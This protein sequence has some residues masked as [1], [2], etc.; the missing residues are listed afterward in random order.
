MELG[1]NII[2]QFN[3]YLS[4]KYENSQTDADGNFNSFT[5]ESDEY[6]T[7]RYGV[8][9]R[10]LSGSIKL[11][12]F[13]ND[14]LDF[15]NRISTNEVKNLGEFKKVNTLFTNDKGRIIDKTT[16]VRLTNYCMLLGSSDREN[17]LEK[18]IDRYI[19]MEDITIENVSDR[20]MIFELLGPQ[21][22]SFMTMICGN[23]VE[24]LDNNTVVLEEL[25]SLHFYLMKN[26]DALGANRFWLIAYAEDSIKLTNALFENKSAFDL[27][28][29]GKNAYDI[30]RVECGIPCSP[31]ELNDS[32][33]PHEV[34]LLS[35]VS[36][37]KGCYIG[38]EV[39]ARLDTYDK[40]QKH[41]TA[42]VFEDGVMFNERQKIY[43]SGN[44]E[45]GEITSVV[46]S[47][48]LN[49]NIGLAIIRKK[50]SEDG[51]KLHSKDDE[52]VYDVTVTKLP[53]TR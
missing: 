15:L 18:W 47:G 52:N 37:S 30:F 36:F 32:F 20:Y 27:K 3:E 28:L 41:L 16:L 7:L 42:V 49:K 53:I 12:L 23:A 14:T 13:G 4:R 6:N 43:N 2:D 17:T 11:K 46:K 51:T 22:N 50:Y 8:G 38:Q 31:N 35:D 10:L 24:G 21:T 9:L 45:V 26:K 33:N 48:L 40:V 44:E 39:I 19:I 34:N 25:D 1:T 5:S 29:I